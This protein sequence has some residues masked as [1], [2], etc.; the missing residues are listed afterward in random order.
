MERETAEVEGEEEG[1]GEKLGKTE[2][3]WEKGERVVK[4]KEREQREKRE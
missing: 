4:E 2:R 3:V 1:G